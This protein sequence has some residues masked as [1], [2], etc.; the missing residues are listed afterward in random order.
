VIEVVRAGPL[1][2]V[3]DLGRPGW[4]HVGV[5]RSGALDRAALSLANR[6]VGNPDGA[7]GLETTLTGCVVRARSSTAVAVTGALAAVRVAGRTVEQAGAVPVAPGDVVE[8][9]SARIGVRSYLAFA[10]GVTVEP[11]LG[12]RSTDTLSGLGPAPLRDGDVLP[13]GEPPAP[14]STV[15]VTAPALAAQEL[16]LGVRLGP[17]DDLFTGDALA[18]LLAEAYTVTPVSNRVG[19]RLAGPTLP[20]ADT[21]ELPPEGIV[22]GAVQVPSNG[23]PLVFLADHPTTGGYPVVAVVDAAGVTA[24]AQARPGATVTFHGP[25]R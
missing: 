12:S 1:T 18:R 15:D 6:L 25:Q 16:R 20:R 19:A 9:G 7:A 17:R 5:P 3:Q 13:L 23:Q 10:G 8:V 22:L 11:V 2:T 21:A 24:L 14:P 4:A